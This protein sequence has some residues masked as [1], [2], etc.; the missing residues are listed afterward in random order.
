MNRRSFLKRASGL[1]AAVA[2]LASTAKPA[3]ANEPTT[4]AWTRAEFAGTFTAKQA[5]QDG[6]MDGFYVGRGRTVVVT[7]DWRGMAYGEDDDA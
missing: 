7:P 4:G 3:E 2:T 1:V 6:Y 5:D